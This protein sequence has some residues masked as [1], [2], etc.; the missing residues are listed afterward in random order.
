MSTS[1]K[2]TNTLSWGPVFWHI[3]HYISIGNL[4]KIKNK[5]IDNYYLFYK[6]IC[7]FIPCRLCQEHYKDLVYIYDLDL[8]EYNRKNLIKFVWNIHN[9]VN[10]SLTKKCNISNSQN[11]SM[12]KELD[13]NKAC[14]FFDIIFNNVDNI[15]YNKLNN[16]N[17][18][19]HTL[20]KILPKSRLNLNNF[21]YSIK[22][23]YSGNELKELYIKNKESIFNF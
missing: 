15:C 12:N 4:K 6:L 13:L 17:L 10:E 5:D 14:K 23:V 20:S 21:K 8:A 11:I 2:K 9:R 3:L 1:V 22:N 7:N 19:I 18:L 16:I